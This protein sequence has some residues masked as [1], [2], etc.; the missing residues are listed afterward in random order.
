MK[1]I[2]KNKSCNTCRAQLLS[3][4][5]DLSVAGIL[6]F[7]RASASTSFTMSSPSTQVH[8][9]LD[10]SGS[11][12]INSLYHCNDANSR[13]S[14]PFIL[15]IRN[16]FDCMA[17]R[18]ESPALSFT[19]HVFSNSVITGRRLGPMR[20]LRSG[21]NIALGFE[22]MI[23]SIK[24]APCE[25]CIVIFVSD[26]GD[27]HGN[28]GRRIKLPPLPCKSTLLTVAVGE[29]FPTS[30]VVNE[31]RVKYHTFGGD[32]IPLVFP[33]SAEYESD[34]E[35]QSEIQ[36][37]VSQLEEIVNSR[38]TQLEYSL[39]ELSAVSDIDCISRQCKRWYNACTIKCMSPQPL[40]LLEKI[41]LVKSTKEQ[42]KGAE[43]IMKNKTSDQTK[44][45]P[46]NL[47]ARRPLIN[48]MSIREKLNTLLEQLNKGR[49]FDELSDVEKQ[50]YLSFGNISGR[51]LAT[52][53]K[54][55]AA[56]F[57]TTKAS[58]LRL[59]KNY[60][61]TKED[62]EL[63]DQINLCS[64]AE[65]MEDA[66][67][68]PDIF[69]D[70][71]TLAGVL[72]GLPFVGRTVELELIPDCAQINPWVVSIK[73]L[74]M[75]IKSA[76]TYDLY[77]QCKGSMESGG[78][79]FNSIVIGGGDPSCSGVFCHLQ[80]FAL[81]KNWLLYFNDSRLAAAS[82]L[83]VHVLGDGKSGEWKLEE[84]ARARSICDLHTPSNSRW[85][86][87]Y[88]NY[89]KMD[90]KF[91]R[92]LVTESPKLESFMTC[93]GLGKFL[94]GTWWLVEQGHVFSEQSLLDRFY[95]VAVELLGRCKLNPNSFFTV[96]CQSS[97]QSRSNPVIDALDS[98][99]SALSGGHLTTRKISQLLQLALQVMF[100]L[101]GFHTQLSDS[102][103]RSRNSYLFFLCG[104]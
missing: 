61:S 7:A 36:W 15:S 32:S 97:T 66:R 48:L 5:Y 67:S 65:Y 45:L 62:T 26:G 104:T 12:Y 35:M 21:T 29:S 55:N 60:K 71:F 14:D 40:T 8:V 100:L 79:K 18:M 92:C 96:R 2:K 47:R 99:K 72:E 52:S 103:K 57:E 23:S 30:L 53:I 94:L 63:V 49:L 11:M 90:E 82:M 34:L 3:V 74:P 13:C 4:H 87:D 101:A 33:L 102:I 73:S 78:V 77:I 22:S 83:V 80:S 42:I 39:G 6:L 75:T 51:F 38:G 70:I 81:T 89:L 54:Y 68:N 25:H 69:S 93:P 64:W 58:L 41:E 43:E 37:V 84:L 24:A 19:F 95:A 76:S 1:K 28:E 10:D 50:A 59:V 86:Y 88:L 16:E 17:D 44:P 31:L 56:N 27:S 85:W 46:S 20:S 98:V 9:I 91:R